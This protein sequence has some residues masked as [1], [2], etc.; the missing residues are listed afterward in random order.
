MELNVKVPSLRV[1]NA[2]ASD[3][4]ELCNDSYGDD[5][6]FVFHVPPEAP[7]FHPNNEEFQDPL[8]YINKIRPVAERYGIC[9]I[10]PPSASV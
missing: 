9:K 5:G 1:N 7:V 4:G 8:L 3:T 10:K 2:P 6:Q